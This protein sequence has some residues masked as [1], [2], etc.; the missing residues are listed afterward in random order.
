MTKQQAHFA[1]ELAQI[2]NDEAASYGLTVNRVVI[3]NVMLDE[4]IVAEMRKGQAAMK[5]LQMQMAKAQ[6]AHKF[7]LMQATHAATLQ[8]AERARV[9]ASATLERAVAEMRYASLRQYDIDINRVMDAEARQEMMHAIARMPRVS[10]LIINGLAGGGGGG[11]GGGSGSGADDYVMPVLHVH[12][13]AQESEEMGSI[14]I[15]ETA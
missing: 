7:A 4:S 9:L 3:E 1:T 13:Q 2:M 12:A 15:Q 8:G 14:A 10:T 6:S 5:A 11:G